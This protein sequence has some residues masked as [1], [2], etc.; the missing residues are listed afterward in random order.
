MNRLGQRIFWL[1]VCLAMTAAGQTPSASVIAFEVASVKL[2]EQPERG[3]IFC[4]VPCSPGERLTVI[5]TKRNVQR[6][7]RSH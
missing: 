5:G 3:P 2:A 6:F 1:F 4:L 7:Q